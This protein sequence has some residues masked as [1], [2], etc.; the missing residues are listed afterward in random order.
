MGKS[1]L[2]KKSQKCMVGSVDN[3]FLGQ[4]KEARFQ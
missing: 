1:K 4:I 3:K 2:A